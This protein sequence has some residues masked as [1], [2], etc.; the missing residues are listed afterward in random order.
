VKAIL[1]CVLSLVC[2]SL[3]AQQCGP[4]GCPDQGPATR[5]LE[6][7]VNRNVI[8][9]HIG[10]PLGG[11]EGIGYSTSPNNIPTCTPRRKMTLTADV[12]RRAKNG[13]WVRIRIWR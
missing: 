10:T 4:N 5:K 13:L 1:F 7:M 3:C 2:G 8:N 12:V 6:E 9:R 11:F